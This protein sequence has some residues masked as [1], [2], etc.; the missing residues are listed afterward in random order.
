[1]HFLDTN[2]VLRLLNAAVPEHDTVR[3]AV[4]LLESRGEELRIETVSKHGVLG[5]RAHDARI[6][7]LMASH[8]T[9]WPLGAASLEGGLSTGSVLHEIRGQSDP[10]C[11]R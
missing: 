1:M 4:E 10:L 9:R 11:G 8:G 7:A 3:T 6:V 2:V 5:K